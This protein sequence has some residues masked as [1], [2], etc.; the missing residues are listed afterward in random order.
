M[1]TNMK[2]ISSDLTPRLAELSPEALC[3]ELLRLAKTFAEAKTRLDS[4]ELEMLYDEVAEAGNVIGG[5]S[6]RLLDVAQAFMREML[7]GGVSA[8]A[9][10]VRRFVE[11]QPITARH[12]LRQAL[13]AAGI[14]AESQNE[15]LQHLVDAGVLRRTSDGRLLILH[16]AREFAQDE[17]EALS[18]RMWRRVERV[19]AAT[20]GMS[21]AE[22]SIHMAGQL[23]VTVEEARNWLRENSIERLA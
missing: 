10:A 13:S 1:K 19:S 18:F 11:Q 4:V 23:G 17:V 12:L 7:L 20:H 3:E 2:K 6:R 21:M 15:N 16:S 14:P 22:A 8:G 5:E 9:R